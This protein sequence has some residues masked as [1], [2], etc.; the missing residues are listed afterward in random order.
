MQENRFRELLSQMTLEEKAGLCSGETMFETKAVERLNIPSI[1]MADGPNGVRRQTGAEDFMGT[2]ESVP[3]T[4]FPSACC[5]GSSFDVALLERLGHCL[6]QNAREEGVHVLL[7]PGVNM[8]RSPLCGRNFEYFSED[9]YLAGVLG[10]AYVKGVQAEGVGA[11]LKHFLANNQETRRRT[12]SSEMDERTMREIY[13][14]AFEMI[15]ENAK[16][17]TVMASYNKID[18]IYATENAEYLRELLR[19][20]WGYQGL[21]VSDWAAVHDRVAVLKGGCNLTMPG[22]KQTD[23]QIVEAVKNG[24]LSEE[25]LDEMCLGMLELVFKCRE[26]EENQRKQSMPYDYEAMHEMATE[27]AGESMVL[28]KNDDHILPLEKEKKIALIGK[29]AEEVRYCGG[30]S[31]K[32]NPYKVKNI[33]EAADVQNH[34]NITY[35][36]GFGFGQYTDNEKLEEAVRAAK[37]AD[38]AVIFAGTPAAMEAEGFD[39]WTMKLPICQNEL[40]EKVCVVQPNTVVVLQNGSAL[41]MPWIE[42]PKAVLEAYLGGE[43]TAEAIWNILTGKV[44]PSGRLAETFPLR[45]EDTPAYLS[46]PGEGNR[47][48][49]PEGIFIGYRYYESR[50]QP[51]LFPFG[52]GLSYTEFTYADLNV[53]KNGENVSVS[54]KVTNNG[55][56]F[57][58]EVVQVYVAPDLNGMNVIRPVRELKY[59][60]KVALEPGESKRIEFELDRRAFAIWDKAT[61]QFRVPGGEYAI[62]IGASARDILLEEKILM[63]NEYQRNGYVYDIMSPICDVAEHPEGRAFL[64]SIMPM[65][66]A[67]I[68]RM[69]QAKAMNEMPYAEL[70]SKNTGLLSEPLQTLQRMLPNISK[71]Q[72]KELLEKLNG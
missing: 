40:I 71:E 53:W 16:P 34:D 33:L 22:E 10:T 60:T 72:W 27:I 21:V 41:E 18:G 20:E 54:V 15:V 38:I 46:W 70:R 31:S 35:T 45:L 37:N 2:N 63:E 8:K 3:A 48:E 14:P 64:D 50:R 23:Y 69:P 47:V 6:G 13:A 65:V 11:S 30:G 39:R 44:N 52:Y 17:W 1:R 29:F 32:V 25:M 36:E 68:A 4:C 43:G 19:N 57:G 42:K 49:Y 24:T 5:T 58:K 59:V 66:N 12:Q 28:L 7:G 9:P 26:Q 55:E 51:V 62:Q 67:V 56:I 61:H